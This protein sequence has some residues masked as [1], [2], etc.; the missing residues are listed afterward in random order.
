LAASFSAEARVRQ[1][2]AGKNI[3]KRQTGD[4]PIVISLLGLRIKYSMQGGA[5]MP[6][7]RTKIFF[8]PEAMAKRMRM[9]EKDS[10]VLLWFRLNKGYAR[11]IE[12]GRGI[13][14][15]M[16]GREIERQVGGVGMET[17]IQGKGGK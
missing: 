11:E 17:R 2:I 7:P 4:L 10:F 8:A 15:K 14:K 6:L 3:S 13:E 16:E 9:C 12:P 5:T 1:A